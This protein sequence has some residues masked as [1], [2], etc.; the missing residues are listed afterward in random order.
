MVYTVWRGGAERD[1]DCFGVSYAMGGGYRG[2]NGYCS[3]L[4]TVGILF[5]IDYQL[6][7]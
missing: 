2:L 7:L 3:L 5:S 1:F 4:F 6:L